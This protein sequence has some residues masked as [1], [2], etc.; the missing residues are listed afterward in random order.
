MQLTLLD[1]PQPRVIEL[2]KS[3]EIDFGFVLASRVPKD[4]AQFVWKRVETV[5][6]TP[7]GHPLAEAK[8]VTLRQIARH[9]LILPPR[10]IRAGERQMLEERFQNLGLDYHV[11]LE[12]SNVEL[13]AEYVEMGLGIAFATTVRELPILNQGK[14]AFI[15]LSH[16]FKPDNIAVILRKD[17]VLVSYKG[18]FLDMLSG[19]SPIARSRVSP[20]NEPNTE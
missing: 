12:A 4:L 10:S 11:I 1:R 2:V 5:L 3:G 9:P 18:A 19:K 13:S 17:K 20:G 14:L 15:P 8:R 7:L 16:Y 6:L